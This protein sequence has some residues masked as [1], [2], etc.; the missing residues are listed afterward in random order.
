MGSGSTLTEVLLPSGA[1]VRGHLPTLGTLLRRDLLPKEL[2]GVALKAANPAWLQVA[3]AVSEDDGEQASRYLAILTASFPRERWTGPGEDDW[4][5]WRITPEDLTSDALDEMDVD[6]LEN[7]VIRV[8]TPEEQS[9]ISRE[10][11]GLSRP[12]SDEEVPSGIPG[13]AEFRGQPGGGAP[14]EDGGDVVDPPV[15]APRARGSG[16]GVRA[17]RGARRGA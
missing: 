11:L 8:V 1:R 4:E 5:Q 17:G 16:G 7:L 10:I 3:R 15:A 2:L 14:G 6:A 9:G 12:D 13:W